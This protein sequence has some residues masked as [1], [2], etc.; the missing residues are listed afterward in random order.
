M[1]APVFEA[2]Q[3]TDGKHGIIGT[4]KIPRKQLTGL[5]A[6]WYNHMSAADIAARV[7]AD[8]FASYAKV[9]SVRNPFDQLVSRCHWQVHQ[10][11]AAY[12]TFDELKELFRNLIFNQNWPDDREIVFIKGQ[13]IVDHAVRFEHLRDDLQQIAITLGLDPAYINLPHTKNTSYARSGRAVADYY[14][15]DTIEA[16]RQR[17]AWVFE[18]FDYPDLPD[19]SP[20]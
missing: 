11:R 17:M 7:G 15:P 9:T 6:Q 4:R 1:G 2:V 16:V 5:N 20:R 19:K 10:G 8:C 3:A 12:E 18:R 13:Y 14:D